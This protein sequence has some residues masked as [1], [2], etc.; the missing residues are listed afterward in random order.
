M[1]L[2]KLTS[3]R[4]DGSSQLSSSPTT[5]TSFLKYE[6]AA[7]IS[8]DSTF[9]SSLSWSSPDSTSLLSSLLSSVSPFSSS[10]ES[11]SSCSLPIWSSSSVIIKK[12]YYIKKTCN[13]C[14]GLDILNLCIHTC[15][16]WW[17]IQRQVKEVRGWFRLIF[18]DRTS[19]SRICLRPKGFVKVFLLQTFLKQ[20]HQ[21]ST[22]CS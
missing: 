10:S 14:E 19:A 21:N 12:N 8:L 9:F 17:I 16:T 13:Y 20:I 5:N 18:R 11:T 15:I 2:D 3:S 4:S 6:C 1:E 22:F 7:K